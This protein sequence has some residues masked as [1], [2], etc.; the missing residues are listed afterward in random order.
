MLHYI[1]TSKWSLVG[2]ALSREGV[3]TTV[4]E[5]CCPEVISIWRIVWAAA[6]H[7]APQCLHPKFVF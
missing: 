7:E 1:I 6:Q 4:G 2:M 5:Y 3:R